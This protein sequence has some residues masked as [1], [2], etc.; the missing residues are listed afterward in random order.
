ME[1]DNIGKTYNMQGEPG[2]AY[3]IILQKLT[4]MKPHRRPRHIV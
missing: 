4:R 2:T 1:R 3:K